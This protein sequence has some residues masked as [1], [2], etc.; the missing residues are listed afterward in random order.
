MQMK[1][2]SGASLAAAAIALAVSGA[3]LSTPAMAK[4]AGVHCMG[5]NA[6]KGKSA[7][8]T[9]S[10]ACKGQNSCKGQGISM[11]KSEKACTKAGGTVG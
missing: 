8:K 9:A 5:V 10:N 2:I 4:K 7:C 1:I 3:A 11:K 6:C